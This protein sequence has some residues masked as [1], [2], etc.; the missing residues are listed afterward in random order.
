MGEGWSDA[1]SS[2][3]NHYVHPADA[4]TLGPTDWMGQVSGKTEDW[5]TGTWVLNNTAGVR[6]Y[7]YSTD[8]YDHYFLNSLRFC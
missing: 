4:D 5:A 1:L 8:L 3:R 2:K 7:I 6:D